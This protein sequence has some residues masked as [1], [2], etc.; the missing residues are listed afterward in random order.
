[1]LIRLLSRVFLALA[2]FLLFDG[3]G[4][5]RAN[6]KTPVMTEL[7]PTTVGRCTFAWTASQ[8]LSLAYEGVPILRKST[9]YIVKA[10]WS[11]TLLGQPDAP[12][13]VTVADLPGGGKTARVTLENDAA[14]CVYT[15]TATPDDRVTLDLAYRLKQDIPAE[16]E[17]AGYLSAPVLLN[18]P[19]TAETTE[20]RRSGRVAV[21]QPAARASQEQNR[22]MPPFTGLTFD[23]RLAKMTVA[24]SGTSPKPVL[25]DARS[26]AQGWAKD[27]PVFWMGIGSPSLPLTLADGERRATFRFAFDAPPAPPAAPEASGEGAKILPL[28]AARMPVVAQT[29]L[30]IPRPKQMQAAE[31]SFRITPET[32]IVVADNA[33]VRDKQGAELLRQE[34]RARF[35][36]D[37]ALVRARGVVEGVNVIAVGEPGR[38]A[39]LDRLLTA[40]RVT[41]P[42]K[43]EGYAVAVTP[44]AVAVVGRD[45]QGSLWGMQTLIQLL[46]ADADGP[47]VRPVR[48]HD[49]PTLSV[50]GIH[51][52]YGRDAY[53][54]Q[55]KLIDRVLSRFKMNTLFIQAEQLRWD[56]DPAIA[57]SWAGRKEDIARQIVFA[58]RRG[59]TMYP[60]VQSHGHMEWLFAGKRNLAFAEDPETPYALNVSDPRAVAHLERFLAEADTLFNAPAFHLGLDEVAMRGRMPHRSKKTFVELFLQ[61]VSH[62]R[63]FFARRGKTVWMWAD[64][65]LPPDGLRDHAPSAEEAAKIRAALPRDIVMVDW[66]YGPHTSFPSLKLLKDAGFPVVAATW[67]NP[68][69]IQNFA[70]AAVQEGALGALQTTWAGYESKESILETDQRKQFTAFVLAADYFWNGGEGPVPEDL[71]YNADAV[72]TRQMAGPQPVDTRTRSGFAVDLTG[73]TTRPLPDWLGYGPE[74]GFDVPAMPRLDDGTLYRLTPGGVLLLGGRLNP[75]ASYPDAVELPL[76][77]RPAAE[78]SLLLA[79]SHR[80]TGGA[81]VGTLVVTTTDGAAHTVD[82]IYGRNIA[83]ADDTAALP[84]APVAWKGRTGA[85]Q[86]VALR[87]LVWTNPDPARTLRSLTI[88]SQD[89]EAAPAVF[90]VTGVDP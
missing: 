7:F 68:V 59:I 9:L 89:I 44:R 32:R 73:L 29:P 19:Y 62:W 42:A 35:G 51:L 20:G 55:T 4:A 69:N 86:P 63:Q 28:S 36:F 66:R 24:F 85:G 54:F 30:V 70:R 18:A 5:A 67:F 25:F 34:I 83:A 58:R 45:R 40:E 14:V 26:D 22:L 65:A 64:M 61:N 74:H 31:K 46:D 87:R 27:F 75:P 50:R 84:A 81:K 11:G 48:I 38:N 21:A 16:F 76:G 1:M 56:A 77:D 12:R 33:N 15:L 3:A 8:G 47:Q 53:P 13:A 57:P 6:P 52:F 60:L 43:P 88:T 17:F 37:A 10:G 82:L 41:P 72:F 49:W 71:P 2:T 80:A 23:T 78:V 90:A 79:A 39:I